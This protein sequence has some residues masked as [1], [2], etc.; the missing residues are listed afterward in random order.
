M[1]GIDFMLANVS[2]A[3]TPLFLSPA[4]SFTFISIFSITPYGE[5]RV[6]VFMNVAI[7]GEYFMMFSSE[8]VGPSFP[9][10]IIPN[11]AESTIYFHMNLTAFLNPMSSTTK[12]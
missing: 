2:A 11:A 10:F 3:F 1:N 4:F 8:T 7:C 6:S 5:R 9:M 12:A